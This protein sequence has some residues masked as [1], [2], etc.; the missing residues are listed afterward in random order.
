M[1]FCTL[2]ELVV[3]CQSQ[4]VSIGQLMLA[5]QA[6]ESGRDASVEFAKMA[7]YYRI[8]KEAREN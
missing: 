6:A 5:E 7:E 3:L 1:H 8:M 4:G 2:Q